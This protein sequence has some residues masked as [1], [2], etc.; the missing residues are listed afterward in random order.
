MRTIKCDRCLKTIFMS[1]SGPMPF[2]ETLKALDVVTITTTK[3]MTVVRAEI[4]GDCNTQLDMFLVGK[5]I[6]AV[7][8]RE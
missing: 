1:P 8:V 5:Q 2:G 7:Q 4:C 6:D 3:L